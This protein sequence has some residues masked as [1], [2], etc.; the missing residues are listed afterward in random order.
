MGAIQAL[1]VGIADPAHD[2]ACLSSITFSPLVMTSPRLSLEDLDVR[3]DTG[4]GVAGISLSLPAGALYVLCGSNGAGKTTTLRVLAGLTFATQGRLTLGGRVVPLDR[5]APRPGL[6]FLP[7]APY[8]DE[9]LTAWQWAAFVSSLKDVTWPSTAMAVAETLQLAPET[10]TER[11]GALSFGTRRKVALWVEFLTTTDVLLLDEPLIGLDPVA[12]EGFHAVAR[13]F[14]ATGRSLI[15]S[16]H[17]LRE[18][19]S[20]ATHVGI[21]RAGRMAREGTLFALCAG[22]SLQDAFLAV[23]AVA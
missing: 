4:H 10:L 5:Y 9:G 17:L 13:D 7:D 3:Y 1:N 11:I 20:L 22:G 21:M 2:A 14:V 19:E 8:L 6:S 23:G 15:L 12:I 18:A 16:T